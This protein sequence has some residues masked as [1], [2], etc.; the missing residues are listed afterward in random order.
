MDHRPTYA[1]SNTLMLK[2]FTGK[3]IYRSNESSV[4]SR[5][6]QRRSKPIIDLC[7]KINVFR[8]TDDDDNT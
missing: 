8:S 4:H 5:G 2:S 7:Y 3:P 1:L 6:K